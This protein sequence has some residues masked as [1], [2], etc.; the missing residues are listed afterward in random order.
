MV[1]I[2]H[3][4]RLMKAEKRGVS[5]PSDLVESAQQRANQTHRGNFS[6]Y[7]ADLIAADLAGQPASTA[8]ASNIVAELA[9]TYAGYLAPRLAAQLERAG[10][11]QP[12]LLH[13]LL[14]GVSESLAAGH[15][16]RSLTAAP[17]SSAYPLPE[18]RDLMAAEA[19]PPVTK[20]GHGQKKPAAA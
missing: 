16:A 7:V 17:S 14:R 10:A 9:R 3:N 20:R 11:D 18:P 5:L 4:L 13:A 15:E 8:Y 6:A 19:P 2:A 12:E 1:A